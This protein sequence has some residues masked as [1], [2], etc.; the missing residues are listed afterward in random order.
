MSLCSTCA[1]ARAVQ[2]RRGQ[3]YVL[4]RNDA[5]PEKYPR[6]PVTSCSGYKP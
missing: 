5:I 6:Q 4:C 1:F 3:T 2:G